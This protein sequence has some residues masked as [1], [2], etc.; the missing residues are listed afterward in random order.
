LFGKGVDNLVARDPYMNVQNYAHVRR[1]S[2]KA[3]L[4]VLLITPNIFGDEEVN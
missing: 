4:T 1:N 2:L 3:I